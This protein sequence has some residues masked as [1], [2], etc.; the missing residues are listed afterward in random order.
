MPKLAMVESTVV[1]L[2]AGRAHKHYWRDV[3]SYTDLFFMLAQRDL[4][5]RYKQTTI[6]ILW[7]VLRPVLTMLVFTFVFGRIAKLPSDGVP[8]ALLVFSGMIPWFFFSSS[9]SESSSSLITNANL[10]SK[11]YFP[12][13]LVPAST[14]LVAAVDLLIGMVL[15]ILT[16][17]FFN[18]WPSWRMLTI[19]IF[20]TTAF[21][22]ALGLGLWFS[23]LNV[24]YRDFQFVVPFL[25]QFGLY[26]SPV[27]FSSSVVPENWA[28]VYALNPMVG[29][30]EGFRWAILGENFSLRWEVQLIS[31]LFSTFLLA[32][33]IAFF[34]RFERD[35]ADII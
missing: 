23:A 34:R 25:L 22:A 35:M 5:V 2:E 6:G 17:L 21:S 14:I 1:V 11:V 19:P 3:L 16:M 30:I 8:Y 32:S 9:V 13:I 27:G 24:R 12:R 31:A 28:L 15:L 18:I 4:A 20:L 7:A 26:L 33:G 29:V 10:L